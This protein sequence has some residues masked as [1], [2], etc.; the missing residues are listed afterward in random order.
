MR[1]GCN[2][3]FPPIHLQPYLASRFGYGGGEFPV[4]EYVSARTLALPFFTRM[5]GILGR[6]WF[7]VDPIASG[8]FGVPAGFAA[9][10]IVS[11]LTRPNRPVVD[12]LVGYLR[13]PL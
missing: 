12:R 5:T 13:D 8:A 11:L 4:C 10:V 9:A 6:P 1:I 2:N 7:G 3:Y